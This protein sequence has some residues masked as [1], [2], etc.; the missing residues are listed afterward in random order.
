MSAPKPCGDLNAFDWHCLIDL[1]PVCSDLEFASAQLAGKSVLVTGAGGSIGSALTK[2]IASC[3]PSRLVLLDTSERGLYE[4]DRDLLQMESA[5]GHVSILGS[6]CDRD[7][8]SSV[9][10][11]NLPQVV[12]HAA[13]FK[14]VPLMERNPFAAIA[15]NALGAFLLTQV[16]TSHDTECL[17]LVSTD[18][19]VDPVSL[20]GASK[21]IAELIL[22][23][24]QHTSGTRMRAVRLGNVL[25]SQ[26]SVVPLFLE[27]IARGGPVTVTHSDA[28]RYFITVQQAVHALLSALS[29]EWMEVILVPALG[30]Q[31]RVVDLAR[32]LIATFGNPELPAQIAFMALRPGDKMEEALISSRETWMADGAG[33]A[34]VG[35]LRPV[36][37]PALALLDLD[38]AMDELRESLLRRDLGR[39]MQAVLRL[40]PEYRPGSLLSGEVERTVRAVEGARA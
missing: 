22:L 6:V 34:H 7:L 27:Q 36:H 8:L 3:S 14:H 29:P 21:R 5:A 32:H 30:T 28:R 25:G 26:G 40:V 18:K 9:F 23:A 10:E 24:L 35:G 1:P 16:A 13:A 15:N 11:Q 17:V 2:A 38:A 31:T 4:I 12:F 20:M 37:S 39:M 33:D 19:A